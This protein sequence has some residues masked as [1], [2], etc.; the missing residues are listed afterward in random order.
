MT[1]L[2]RVLLVWF[3]AAGLRRLE[4]PIVWRGVM[5]VRCH[6]MLGRWVSF[7]LRGEIADIILYD[8]CDTTLPICMHVRGAAGGS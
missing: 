7:P 6:T 5:V 1:H 3:S 4:V 8:M 2:V